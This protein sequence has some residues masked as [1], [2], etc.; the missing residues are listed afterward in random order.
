MQQT[1]GVL[2]GNYNGLSGNLVTILE[3]IM[4]ARSVMQPRLNI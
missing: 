4:N 1:S 2:L 3:G